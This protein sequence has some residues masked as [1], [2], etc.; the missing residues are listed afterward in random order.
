MSQIHVLAVIPGMGLAAGG[1]TF[2]VSS[3]CEAT[4][5]S[6]AEQSLFTIQASSGEPEHLPDPLLVETVRVRGFHFRRLRLLWSPSFKSALRSF[7]RERGV[8]V[9]H[10]HSIWSQPNHAAVSVA[11]E[12]GLPHIVSTHGM[13]EPWAWRY[14]AW[15]KRPAWWLWQHRDLCGAAVLRATAQQEVEALRALGFRQPIALIPNGVELPEI[16]DTKRY[17]DFSVSEFQLSAFSPSEV[18][19]QKSAVRTALFLSRI[20]PKKGLLNLVTAWSQVRPS[21]WRV[22][23]CGPD[24]CGHAEQVKRAV[25]EAGLSG[26]FDFKSSVYGAEKEAL[27]ANADLFVLPTFSENFG[28]VVAEALAA[29]VPVITTTGTPWKELHTR[30]CGWWIDIGVEPLA[31]AIREAT[32]LPDQ[33]RHEMGQRGRR[34]VMEKYSWSQIGKDMLSVYEWMLGTGPTPECIA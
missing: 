32:S 25:A 7:C 5:N 18:R 31:A 6:G 16:R 26:E 21:G 19:G 2:S 27:Y 1:P 28:I 17:S 14:H 12:I 33:E 9:I 11:R 23:V 24:E 13:L 29:G 8:Q 3:L 30:Q 22:V 34:L 15:K 10:S 20:H 4:A